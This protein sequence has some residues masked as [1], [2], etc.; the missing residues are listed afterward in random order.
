MPRAE[1]WRYTYQLGQWSQ[2]IYDSPRAA[3]GGCGGHGHAQGPSAPSA[4][5]EQQRLLGGPLRRQASAAPSAFTLRLS[6]SSPESC[7]LQRRASGRPLGA[8]CSWGAVRRGGNVG[9]GAAHQ[10]VTGRH[11]RRVRFEWSLRRIQCAHGL[12]R[13]AAVP[14]ASG[15]A[16]AIAKPGSR[17]VAPPPWTCEHGSMVGPAE[18]EIT[19]LRAFDDVL[20]AAFSLTNEGAIN[21]D[22]DARR[23]WVSFFGLGRPPPGPQILPVPQHHRHRYHPAHRAARRLHR[24]S[25]PHTASN[26]ATASTRNTAFGGLQWHRLSAG[27]QPLDPDDRHHRRRPPP[28]PRPPPLHR[29]RRQPAVAAITAAAALSAAL[30]PPPPAPLPPGFAQRQRCLAGRE[31]VDTRRRQTTCEAISQWSWRFRGLRSRS[32]PTK[33]SQICHGIRSVRFATLHIRRIRR[34][35]ELAQLRVDHSLVWDQSY[36]YVCQPFMARSNQC[37]SGYQDSK[38]EIHRTIATHRHP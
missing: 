13:A 3:A 10:L 22:G 12:L 6:R 36:Q 30:P 5:V 1:I 2:C 8:L 17:L 25:H 34:D 11:L 19:D 35:S 20:D 23:R 9:P 15:A 37:G 14:I 32:V 33:R 7:A 38:F 16:A 31:R 29:L 28:S 21:L 27:A 24:H 4:S 18:F 26:E